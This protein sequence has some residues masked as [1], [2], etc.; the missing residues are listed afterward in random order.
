MTANNHLP[1]VLPAPPETGTEV[2]PLAGARSAAPES[3]AGRRVQA[4]GLAALAIVLIPAA[5]S[6][7]SFSAAPNF[8]VGWEVLW[9][10]VAAI[11]W[12][13]DARFP[14]RWVGWALLA[15]APQALVNL[16][17]AAPLGLVGLIAL[18]GS[19]LLARV[20]FKRYVA[21]GFD[22]A[23]LDVEVPFQIT[24]HMRAR[25]RIG[26]D[27]VVLSQHNPGAGGHVDQAIPLAELSI[28]EAGEVIDADSWPLPGG[29]GLRLRQA[30]AVRLVAGRQQ[31]VVHV[32]DPRLVTAILLRRQTAAWPQRTGPQNLNSWHAL[33]EWA[34]ARSTALRDGRK[35]QALP[36]WR[37]PLGFAAAVL[38]T[39]LAFTTGG[40]ASDDP[41]SWIPGAV[42]LALA[43][44][45][46]V[47]WL[48][49]RRKMEFVELQSLPPNSPPWGD[50]RSGIA[51]IATWRPWA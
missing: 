10:V 41:T 24:R 26:R 11:G 16:V 18:I 7:L 17:V 6:T 40:Q 4:F 29:V 51:P 33:R 22:L 5:L 21:P 31:W 47:E 30:P 35:A 3:V 19:P 2:G 46:L 8:I 34:A 42:L 23:E 28:A 44:Y 12:L 38:G 27:R 32:E 36:G 43:G 45:L 48:R 13:L 9:I 15:A 39:F 37:A 50:Q 25:L 20:A 14:R 1:E 49:V